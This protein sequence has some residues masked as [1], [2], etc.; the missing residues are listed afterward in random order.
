MAI[1][2]AKDPETGLEIF[3]PILEGTTSFYT[4]DVVDEKGIAITTLNTLT[5]TLFDKESKQ[6][7]NSRNKGSVLNINGGEFALGK[8]KMTFSSDD[9]VILNQRKEYEDH[10][11]L[12]SYS[13]GPVTGNHAVVIRVRNLAR[14]GV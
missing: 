3:G 1:T 8:L 11:A 7:I 13:L 9:N 5:L 14:V 4:A 12:F 10:I 6:T 2:K